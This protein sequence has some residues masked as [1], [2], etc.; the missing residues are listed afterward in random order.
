M[1]YTLCHGLEWHNCSEGGWGHGMV[2]DQSMYSSILN[3]PPLLLQE[4]GKHLPVQSVNAS[5]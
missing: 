5:C 1:E 4:E 3:L 2:V